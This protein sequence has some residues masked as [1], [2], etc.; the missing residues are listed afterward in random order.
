VDIVGKPAIA[1]VVAVSLLQLKRLSAWPF[2]LPPREAARVGPAKRRA[3]GLTSDLPI[4]FPHDVY[5]GAHHSRRM[6]GEAR[7]LAVRFARPRQPR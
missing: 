6:A 1:R 4:D 7:A 2:A 3:E 5:D